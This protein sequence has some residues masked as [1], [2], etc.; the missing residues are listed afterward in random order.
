MSAKVLDTSASIQDTEDWRAK[1]RNWM[2]NDVGAVEIA[3]DVEPDTAAIQVVLSALQDRRAKGQTLEVHMTQDSPFH[4]LWMALGLG[5]LP[6]TT[7]KP[8][9]E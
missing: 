7:L 3:A 5:A 9:A 2:A 8:S 6:E 4:T 1:L